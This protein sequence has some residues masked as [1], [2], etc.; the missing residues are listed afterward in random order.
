MLEAALRGLKELVD[1]HAIVAKYTLACAEGSPADRGGSGISAPAS[2]AALVAPV[3]QDLVSAAVSVDVRITVNGGHYSGQSGQALADE[4]SARGR[5]LLDITPDI[6]ALAL[7]ELQGQFTGAYIPSR[8]E[9]NAALERAYIAAVLR[10]FDG[11]ELGAYLAPLSQ[12]WLRVKAARG[13]SSNIGVA[14]GA[15]RGLVAGSGV[16][17]SE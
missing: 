3:V 14:T 9:L 10:R 2:M 17:Y 6:R 15:L 13:W 11:E 8:G 5:D 7:A 12:A 1:N 4:L 16:E